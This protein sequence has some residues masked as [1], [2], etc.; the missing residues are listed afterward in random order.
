MDKTSATKTVDSG[1][2]PGQVK[3]MTIFT[4]S[5]KKGQCEAS[6]V[7]VDKWAGGN[8]T[9][10]PKGPTSLSP[11]QGNLAKKMHKNETRNAFIGMKHFN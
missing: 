8:L 2:I 11:D 1:S 3:P 4:L 6:T 7:V 5:N 9:R 10:R